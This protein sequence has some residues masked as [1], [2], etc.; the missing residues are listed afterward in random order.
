MLVD[1][2]KECF[3]S[4]IR[5]YKHPLLLNLVADLIIVFFQE[6]NNKINYFFKYL[7]LFFLSIW[8]YSSST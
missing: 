3:K 2:F 1:I 8:N 5:H 7:E 6:K 4:E